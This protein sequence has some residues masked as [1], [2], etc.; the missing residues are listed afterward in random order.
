MPN[1]KSWR[2]WVVLTWLEQSAWKINLIMLMILTS[3][4]A[5]S[6][7]SLRDAA[8]DEAPGAIGSSHTFLY[9]TT[10]TFRLLSTVNSAVAG[11]EDGLTALDLRHE[12]FQGRVRVALMGGLPARYPGNQTLEP[13]L[14]DVD[15]RAMNIQRAFE[16]WRSGGRSALPGLQ[17]AVQEFVPVSIAFYNTLRQAILQVAT[18]GL[19]KRAD[20]FLLISTLALLSMLVAS[21]G[22][23][24]MR[25]SLRRRQATQHSL[26]L[27]EARLSAI[28]DTAMVGIISL[29]ER[30]RI[31]SFNHEAEKILGY[32]A[33][34][35]LG[36]PIDRLIPLPDR[37]AHHTHVQSFLAG[38]ADHRVMSSWRTVSGLHKDGTLV[39]LMVGI[40]KIKLGD[41]I[42]MTAIFRDMGEI[43]DAEER[44]QQLASDRELQLRRA[45]A[46]NQAKSQFLATMS[47]E[48]RTPLNA[49]IGFSSLIKS[50]IFGPIANEKYREYIR[51][52][53]ASGEHL[54]SLIN[55][56]LD[57]S[58]IEA[59]KYEF[60][61]RPIDPVA[62]M[63]EVAM[64]LEPLAL[65]KTIALVMPEA[66]PGC[67]VL[68]DRRAVHQILLNLI[69]NA[70]KFTA[71][72][73]RVQLQV[74][75][76]RQDDTIA[77]VVSDNGRGIPADR[78]ADLG[79]PFVQV[80]G[81][82]TRDQGGSGLGMA[83][84]KSLAKGMNGSIELESELGRS[85]RG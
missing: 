27:S 39:P 74:E 83:I 16:A 33:A 12:L 46:A 75:L 14:H 66:I 21:S 23:L 80:Q 56:I 77:L 10:E 48:L 32:S 61:I 53:H 22:S 4:V 69:G 18:D 72:G 58:R 36:Q 64:L 50:E 3:A 28:L 1:R 85:C 31:V 30:Y 40:S 37:D 78:L 49:I 54:L 38:E 68:G 6:A 81:A 73:G 25:Q 29:N 51:D 62:A 63:I 24:V 13:I 84:C 67:D 42:T 44:L 41:R 17:A 70:I 9:L 20:L 7:Y 79:Q 11:Q 71:D 15:S 76:R 55:D 59:S 2:R 47:H 45:Q 65:E 60:E 34:E 57:L 43:R 19:K 5:L 82:Y 26:K 52:V 8:R 35:M